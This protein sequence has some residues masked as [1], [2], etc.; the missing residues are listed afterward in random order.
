MSTVGNSTRINDGT[1]SRATIFTNL[2]KDELVYVFNSLNALKMYN[3]G[4]PQSYYLPS[5]S[6]QQVGDV[7]GTVDQFNNAGG[8]YSSIVDNSVSGMSADEVI[9]LVD[10]ILK[11]TGGGS[12]SGNDNDDD[13]SLWEKIGNAIGNL[14]DGIVDV[15]ASVIEKLTDAILSVIH[16]LTGYTD[17]NGV[18]HEGLLGKLT[19]LI[20]VD[21][22]SFLGSV[23]DWLPPEIVTLFT[24]TLIFAVFFAIWKMIRG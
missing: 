21:F 15:I 5:G 23:F 22:N 24:A 2:P 17:D 18:Y 6:T 7:S 19:S 3:S 1:Q 8:Y 9:K 13:S 12:G 14:I 20:S 10:T 4:A 16:L 11:N